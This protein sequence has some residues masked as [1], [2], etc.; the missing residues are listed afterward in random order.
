[1]AIHVIFTNAVLHCFVATRQN[2][3]LKLFW[4]FFFK[5]SSVQGKPPFS[6]HVEQNQ[7]PF[8]ACSQTPVQTPVQSHHPQSE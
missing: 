2:I 6:I 8:P 3:I 5:G 1:M 7:M 4:F